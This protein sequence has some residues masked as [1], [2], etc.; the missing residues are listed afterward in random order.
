MKTAEGET[1]TAR[2]PEPMQTATGDGTTEDGEVPGVAMEEGRPRPD[3]ARRTGLPVG[4]E[5][6]GGAGRGRPGEKPAL[7]GIAER[8]EGYEDVPAAA[9]GANGG[10]QGFER[11]RRRHQSRGIELPPVLQDHPSRRQAQ[12]RGD[13]GFGGIGGLGTAQPGRPLFRPRGKAESGEPGGRSGRELRPGTGKRPGWGSRAGRRPGGR[14][15]GR[16]A[17]DRARPRRPPGG[18]AGGRRA[19][20]SRKP[21][22][23]PPTARGARSS[24]NPDGRTARA[25]RD[26]RRRDERGQRGGSRARRGLASLCRR[27]RRCRRSRPLLHR[28]H[29]LLLDDR[30]HHARRRL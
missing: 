14:G 11:T 22:A 7:D 30:L 29:D 3:G 27:C 21:P 18:P 13:R 19:R 8:P 2:T 12:S 23:P 28:L 5:E 4:F 6:E 10:K 17:V 25:P 16:S 9:T 1:G 20:R 15:R 24:P 26:A